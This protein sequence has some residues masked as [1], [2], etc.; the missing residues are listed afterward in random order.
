MENQTT[1]TYIVWIGES[2][3]IASFREVD[4][5]EK[6]TFTFHDH[7]M[8]FLQSLQVAGYRFQ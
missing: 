8:G 7:F 3:R 4:G 5:Y 6:R 1:E 2:D